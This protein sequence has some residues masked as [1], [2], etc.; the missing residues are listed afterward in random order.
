[1]P[2][3]T[4]VSLLHRVKRWLG[5]WYLTLSMGC[6]IWFL[7]IVSP[8]LSNDLF[9]PGFEPTTAHTYLLDVFSAHL[10]VTG[11]ASIDLFSP[12]E[13]IIKAYGLQ[14]TTASSK[15]TYPRT[16]ALTEYTTVEDAVA[17]FRILNP[18]YVFNLVT[19]YCWADFDKRWQI[20]HTVARQAR[21][22]RDF[23]TN[24]A[25]YLEPYLRN[26]HWDD[27]YAVY[28]TS[29]EFAVSDAIVVT[30][31]GAEWYAGL[32][33]AFSSV[34]VEAAYWT[35]KNI[36]SFQLQW[37]NDIQMG[38]RE[39]IT[40]TN[41]LGWE[42][43]LTTSTIAYA[44]RSSAW[45]SFVLNWAFYDDLWGAAVTNSSLV[46]GASNFIGDTTM[47][48][49]LNLYPFTPCSRIVHDVLGPFQSIDAFLQQPPPALV[50]AVT[51]HS[52]ALAVALLRDLALVAALK[53]LPSLELDPAPPSW[54]SSGYT[55]F[56][57]SPLC[58]FSTGTAHVQ[59]SFSFGDTCGSQPSSRFFVTPMPTVFA[60]TMLY[61]LQAPL[62]TTC[63]ACSPATVDVYSS[64]IQDA[65]AVTSH[66]F[67]NASV[68]DVLLP[69]AQGAAA[70]LTAAGIEVIQ[71]AHT[72]GGSHTVLRQPLVGGMSWSWIFFGYAALY[73][74][75]LGLREVVSFQ[76]DVATFRLISERV[77]P[78]PFMA[79]SLEVP[80][81][82]S[83]Y[84]WVTVVMTT[85][86]FMVVAVVT[87]AYAISASRDMDL[88]QLH[89]FNRIV[90]P[91]WIGRPLL[92]LR[93][94]AAIT[95]LCTAPIAFVN[96]G[97]VNR[98]E[99]HPRSVAHIVVLTGEATWLTYVANDV[100]LVIARER[101]RWAAPVSSYLVWLLLI[102]LE[103][104]APIRATA[105]VDRACSRVD[106]V[107]NVVCRSGSVIIGSEH[108]IWIIVGVNAV[109]VVVI[110]TFGCARSKSRSTI[111]TPPYLVPA[112]AAEYL[113]PPNDI[114]AIDAVT[115]SMSGFLVLHLGRRRYIF[116]AKL[117]T[118]FHAESNNPTLV[119]VLSGKSVSESSTVVPVAR[120]R[121]TVTRAMAGLAYLVVTAVGSLSYIQLSTVNLANDFWWA[122]FNTTG[123]QTFVANWFNWFVLINPHQSSQR[124][125]TVPYID[126]NDYST[127]TTLILSSR[128]YPSMLQYDSGTDLAL[129]I[130]GLRSMDGCQAPW[131]A[132]SYCWLDFQQQLEMANTPARQARCTANYDSNGA[133][134]LEAV[135]RNVDWSSFYDCWGTSFDVAIAADV[136][137]LMA[138]GG[139]WLASLST[140]SL[141][142][143]DEVRHW[144]AHGISTYTTQWQNY[145][146]LGLHDTFSVQNAFGMQYA[147]TLR[148]LDG[149]Y[150]V[151][152]STSWKMYWTFASDLW[153]VATNGSGMSGRSLIRQSGHFAFRNQSLETVL[154]LNGT[155]AAPI[156]PVY[157]LFRSTVGPF[158]SVDIYHV[159]CPEALVRLRHDIL[160]ML[161]TILAAQSIDGSNAAQDSYTRLAL[162]SSMSP[163]PK[164][165][166]NGPYRCAGGN[167]L[168]PEVPIA[169]N[170]SIGMSQFAGVDATC[171]TSFNE[172]IFVSALQAVF[173]VATSGVAL[174]PAA[175]VAT[176]CAAEVIA[177]VGC[178]AFLSSVAL[179]VTTY[180]KPAD[181]LGFRRRAQDL[182]T[183]IQKGGIGI[184]QYTRSVP[185]NSLELFHQ[186]LFDATDETMLYTSW[187]LAYDWAAAVREVIA[188][189]GDVASVSIVT[190]T[191]SLTTYPASVAELP[192]NVAKYVRA[193]CVYISFVVVAI[194]GIT[195]L[196]AAATHCTCEGNNFFKLSRVGGMVWV[197]RPLLIL[198]SVSALCILSTSML[199]LRK[200]GSG[201]VL[202]AA[203]DQVEPTMAFFTK[204]LA[205]SELGWIVYIY[206]DLCMAITREYAAKYTTKTAISV[207][208]VAAVLSFTLPVVHSVTLQRSCTIVAMDYEILCNSGVVTI[209]SLPRLLVLVVIVLSAS[210]TMFL[211]TRM[212][213][214]LRAYDVRDSYLLSCGAN[215]LFKKVGWVH[216]GIYHMD[217]ASAVL[218]GLL[219][220]PYKDDLYV[221]DIKTWRTLTISREEVCNATHH[222][223][224]PSHLRYTV[225]LIQ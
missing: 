160:T 180:F 76:G 220:M 127:T 22:D 30:K 70:E 51:A 41:M 40:V 48:A 49:L 113:A 122:T 86:T 126:M 136:P 165:L 74:W 134:Y 212:C 116:D 56:G 14:T 20:A 54:R 64:V 37:S 156:N 137:T 77:E 84:I 9:W 207:M 23:A 197:G 99:F 117:W 4:G 13:A 33:N 181:L 32:Q 100:L 218:T 36:S 157:N 87:A 104:A 103:L 216:Q 28:G 183:V 68:V 213:C 159:P 150:R 47:E 130:D 211:V 123:T 19:L 124:F 184:A 55:F 2:W 193:T 62:N 142:V 96:D 120:R 67:R 210:T 10:T 57:G 201:T 21:C 173:A 107:V 196:Y 144:Q 58:T 63:D 149:S 65:V 163:V 7:R 135:L 128:L 146:T 161:F 98:F 188:I 101:S 168:C 222:R 8:G 131:I 109:S 108:R 42:Q 26:V 185:S 29:F 91:V 192:L 202:V 53:A 114:W 195:V 194:A 224:A 39:S 24:G 214:N 200:N 140:N 80:N 12:S 153:A 25:V 66:L 182:E 206:D 167:M 203:R 27:W 225:P 102:A 75:A 151:A 125:D 93:A 44:T 105:T 89:Y 132:T 5:L 88:K 199:Q 79:S 121:V 145:K 119:M 215:Y 198:R 209:G 94:L 111:L 223:V 69:Y 6:N 166:R 95:A 61:L 73:E 18:T 187:A 217:Y 143:P 60:T 112:G 78:I 11:N 158:G 129:M 17:S 52:S 177:P 92:L 178:S 81:S 16:L 175:E 138:N 46:R 71:F 82:T 3:P 1:M 152:T 59:P 133:V 176:A 170:F 208:V 34:D 15:P 189:Q 148:S 172:W 164:L 72:R 110:Y 50:A 169:F 90:G 162:M 97:G 43:S 174:A 45:S 186:L 205:A 106:F 38:I 154:S 190:G 191:S 35:S 31:E 85:A 221:F 179:F 219:V 141:S 83:R 171:H 204:V 118:L 115:A 147:L 155:L 139:S